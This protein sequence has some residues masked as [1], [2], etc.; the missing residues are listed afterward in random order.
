MLVYQLGVRNTTILYFL[1]IVIHG[2]LACVRLTPTSSEHCPTAAIKQHN[3][4][5]HLFS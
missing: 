3:T 2:V 5:A 1:N 4:H